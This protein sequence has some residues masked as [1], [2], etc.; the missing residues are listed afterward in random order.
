MKCESKLT[1]DLL[2]QT[3]DGFPIFRNGI[4]YNDENLE[5]RLACSTSKFPTDANSFFWEKSQ[6]ENSKNSKNQWTEP[7]KF[8]SAENLGSQCSFQASTNQLELIFGSD[9]PGKTR[10]GN[11]TCKANGETASVVIFFEGM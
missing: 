7:Q 11:Y 5:I 1:I 2:N 9:V 10:E 3:P 6:W 4:V 8:C